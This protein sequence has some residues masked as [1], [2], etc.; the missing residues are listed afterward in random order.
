MRNRSVSISLNGATLILLALLLV[1]FAAFLGQ[2]LFN[3]KGEPREALVAVSMLNQHNWILPESCGTDI[4]YKPP[5][6]AWCIALLGWL[7]GGHV[8]EFLSRLPSALAATAMLIAVFRFFAKRESAPLAMVTA[9][10]AATAFEVHRA[11]TSCRV[12]ML[13][14][15]FIVTAILAMYSS[16]ERHPRSRWRLPWLGI[17]LMSGGVLTKGPVG[18]LLPCGTLLVLRLMKGDSPLRAISQLFFAGGLALVLPALWYVAAYSQGGEQF[19]QLALEENFGRFTGKMSYESHEHTFLYNFQTLFAGLAPYT[20]LLLASL[21]AWKRYPRITLSA[22]VIW[23]RLR[24]IPAERLLAVAAAVVIFVFYCIPKSKRS[25]YLLPMYPF[26]AFWIAVYIRWMV[27]NAPRVLR[28][29]GIFMAAVGALASIAMLLII[30]GIVQGPATGKIAVYFLEARSSGIT[31]LLTGSICLAVSLGSLR[32]LIGGTPS[33]VVQW[34]LLDTL[35][36][37]WMFSAAIQPMVLNPKSDRP[38]ASDIETIVPGGEAL[39]GF[40]TADMLRYYTAGFYLDDRIQAVTSVPPAIE[41][42]GWILAGDYDADSL[43][44]ILPQGTLLQPALEWSK[45]SCDNKQLTTLYRYKLPQEK[46][47]NT[48]LP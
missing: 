11:A 20:L 47:D 30:T 46:A 8:T 34:T 22:S 5:M 1:T 2:T 18:M 36:I 29:Y 10:V 40:M 45:K 16:W 3:T 25:V 15:A 37:Y 14:T 38:M 33:S 31:A 39:Y 19:L 13:L 12:D 27:H 48:G 32:V 28:A 42:S 9:L 24:S 21:T 23:Q 41:D 17:L 26:L 7:N 35:F 43:K 44:A 4:P 6:L